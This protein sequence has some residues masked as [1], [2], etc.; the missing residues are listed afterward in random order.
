MDVTNI[1]PRSLNV[2]NE[3]LFFQ[4]SPK[5]P[6]PLLIGSGI[7]AF[8]AVML[9]VWWVLFPEQVP[10]NGAQVFF[11]M[12]WLGAAWGIVSGESWIRVGIVAVLCIYVLGLMNQPSL[13]EGF[14]K[15]NPS[16]HLSKLLALVAVVL[17]YEKS[18][19]HWF[20]ALRL[21]EQKP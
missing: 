13:I 9:L 21:E 17:F 16:D 6:M 18:T 1:Y 4:I 14:S 19:R 5:P 3:L 7:L 11:I 20:K 2:L 8:N 10:S 12:L 15:I